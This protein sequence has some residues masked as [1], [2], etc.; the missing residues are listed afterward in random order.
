MLKRKLKFG[1]FLIFVTCICIAGAM[2]IEN[3][4]LY[5]L[6][7][8]EYIKWVDFDVSE[9][10]LSD[11]LEVVLDAY[12]NG[13]EIDYSDLLAL[14]GAKYGGNFDRYKKSD[15]TA[16][17]ERLK[18][19]E[20]LDN[21]GLKYNYYPYFQEAYGAVLDGYVGSISI[22][23]KEYYGLRVFSPVANGYYYEHYDDFGAKRDYGYKR[24]HLGHDMMGS[25]GT[26]IIA[27]ESGYI[28]S[29]G[30]N[31][32]GGWRIG[33]R[34]F[35]NKRY[36]Y[37]AHLRKDHPFAQEFKEGDIIIAGEVIGYLGMTGYSAKENVNNINV[38]HLHLGIQLIFDPSQKDGYN[39]IWINCYE[40]VKFLSKNKMS[41][42][43]T[44][45]GKDYKA[46]SEIAIYDIPD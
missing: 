34:S 29:V 36:Y 38:P 9:E 5:R 15:L 43:K 24:K 4:R 31:Q 7:S 22:D 17:Y 6:T 37:Y 27:I 21:I 18:N 45:N 10:A 14:L 28:E 40:I 26:P 19:G 8:G 33:I 11:S 25:V 35:D 23:G 32:Y 1:F 42:I 39:Q 44:E 20:S 41:V 16:I 3:E 46:K 30:W 12:S 2:L 13:N